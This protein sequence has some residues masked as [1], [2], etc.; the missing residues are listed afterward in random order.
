MDFEL[1][2]AQQEIVRQVRALCEKFDDEYWRERD[3]KAEFPHDFYAAVA[4]AGYLGVAIP[5]AYGGSGLG[6]TEAALVMKEVA[7]SGRGDG[8]GERGSSFHLRRQPD[9]LPWHRRAEAALPAA[10]G[11]GRSACGV[12]GN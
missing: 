7:G 12:R 10:S 1:T 5:E 11:A 4:K 3:A 9:R 2:A 8:G 6:I